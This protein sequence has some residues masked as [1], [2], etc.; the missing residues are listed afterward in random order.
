MS[1]E[2]VGAAAVVMGTS[3]ITIITVARMYFNSRRRLP[4][5]DA[6]MRQ[7]LRTEERLA[8]IEQAVDA[9]AIEVER[10]SEGQRFLA[11]LQAERAALPRAAEPPAGN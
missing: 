4:D 11:K 8:R 3:M 9:I 6:S 5:P 10:I 1:G 7:S 2:E